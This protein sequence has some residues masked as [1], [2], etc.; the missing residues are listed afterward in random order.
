MKG[1]LPSLV[2]MHNLT[3]REGGVCFM[4]CFN[5]NASHDDARRPKGEGE[6]EGAKLP[7]AGKVKQ[8]FL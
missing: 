5:N 2:G 1:A 4:S 3:G 7:S 6:A 8:S